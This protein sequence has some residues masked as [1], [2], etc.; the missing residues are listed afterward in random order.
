ML[1][2]YEKIMS[3][4]LFTGLNTNSITQFLEETPLSFIK[5]RPQD[6]IIDSSYQCD[7]VKCFLS[8]SIQ[9]HHKILN[10]KIDIYQII[11]DVAVLGAEHLFSLDKY[12]NATVRAV[13]ESSFMEFSK[14]HYFRMLQS[15]PLMLV[16]FLNYLT[17]KSE[18]SFKFIINEDLISPPKLLKY[19]MET[20]T[21]K[22][23]KG[24]KININD[25]NLFNKTINNQLI[26][27]N[28][29]IIEKIGKDYF[30][31]KDRL[32]LMENL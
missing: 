11:E 8:G 6:I 13:T 26:F 23:S 16:N 31:I 28:E 12:Y 3:L 2:M 4:P 22:F 21:Y 20:F 29:E 25:S 7:S 24:I 18:K 10:G 27:K 15:D 1:S 32:S 30:I 17:I 14:K 19:I 9:V 5:Y